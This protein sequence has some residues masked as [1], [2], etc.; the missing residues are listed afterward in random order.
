MRRAARP[1]AAALSSYP[2]SATFPPAPCAFVERRGNLCGDPRLKFRSKFPLGAN[3]P[4]FEA[5]VAAASTALGCKPRG[6]ISP[7]TVGAHLRMT[8]M[9]LVKLVFPVASV[10]GGRSC[11]L[12][13]ALERSW[14]GARGL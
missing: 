2:H 6:G 9:A 1:T 10:V 3:W 14:K 4:K 7:D 13:S 5:L 11:P 8:K 12:F